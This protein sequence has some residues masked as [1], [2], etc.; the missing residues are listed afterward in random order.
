[1]PKRRKKRNGIH[2]LNWNLLNGSH[3]FPGPDGGTC[4]NEA[5]IIA[6][7]F[8][9]KVVRTS[10]DF[11]PCF[12]KVIGQFALCLNDAILD[13]DT[14]NRVLMPFVVRLAG[15]KDRVTVER[16]RARFMMEK[17]FRLHVEEGNISDPDFSDF[18]DNYDMYD[19]DDVR[20]CLKEWEAL[21][22]WPHW[23]LEKI[24]ESDV[25][26]DYVG[27]LQTCWSCTDP[28]A[29]LETD[30][31]ENLGG[32]YPEQMAAILDK[33]IKMGKHAKV[34]DWKTIQKRLDKYKE[35]ARQRE[36]RWNRASNTGP[37]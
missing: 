34:S 19:V 20:K 5:A 33:A 1:M 30:W 22:G 28:L 26:D 16:R 29:I 23:P 14:R 7:G 4:I 15:T 17:M 27:T 13:E 10:D 11:P 24:L 18:V 31:F 2:N 21:E 35:E 8:E 3:E 36:A 25:N 6:R 32:T 9:Y 37:R 12:S